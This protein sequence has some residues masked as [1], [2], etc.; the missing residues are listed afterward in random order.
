MTVKNIIDYVDKIRPNTFDF[1]TKLRWIGDVEGKLRVEILKEAI[2]AVTPPFGEDD[3]LLIPY[4]YADAYAYYIIA[5]IDFLC[6]EF[7]KYYASSKA[8]N[9]AMSDY[10]KFV[11]R[12]GGV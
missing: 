7:E 10:A 11:V 8:Y 12:R 3:E 4:M 2:D 1:E 6:G 9:K 5:M